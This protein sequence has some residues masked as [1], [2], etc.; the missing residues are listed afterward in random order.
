MCY[1]LHMFPATF[2][3]DASSPNVGIPPFLRSCAKAMETRN[4]RNFTFRK[5]ATG[6]PRQGMKAR[7]L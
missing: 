2:H 1:V 3:T 7:L 6:V 5:S 4:F